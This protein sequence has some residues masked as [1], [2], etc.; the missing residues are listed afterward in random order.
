MILLSLWYQS[1]HNADPEIFNDKFT[2]HNDHM[3]GIL[4]QFWVCHLPLYL[5]VLSF[6]CTSCLQLA[7]NNL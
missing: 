4:F 6:N 5:K 1:N 3:S 2:K 7:G